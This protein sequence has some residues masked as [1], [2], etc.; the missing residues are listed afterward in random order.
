MFFNIS[1]KISHCYNLLFVVQ[2][3]VI[4]VLI[5]DGML[6]SPYIFIFNQQTLLSRVFVI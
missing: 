5:V 1:L 2:D 3:L 6:H 4:K